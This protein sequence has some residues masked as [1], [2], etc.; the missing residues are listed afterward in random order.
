[1]KKVIRIGSKRKPKV[2]AH[3][4]ALT[5]NLKAKV[6][7]IQALIPI[8]LEAVAEELERDVERL[9]GLKHS[10]KGG[11][12]GHYRWGGQPGS[13][14][15]ADQ[16]VKTRI[17][18][19]RNVLENAEVPLE[20]YRLLQRPRNGDEGVMRKVLY[21]LSCRKYEQCAEAVPE[22]LGLSSSSI[23]RRFIQVSGSRLR[24]LMERDLSGYDFVALFI[25]GKSFAQD[26]MIIALGVTM[27]GEKVI[28]GFIQAAT[29]KEG[30]VKD[31][32]HGL[33]ERGL[34][35]EQGLLCIIDGAKGIRS[36]IQKVFGERALVQRCQWHKRENV[37]DYLPKH[38]HVTW[39]RK[40]QRAYEKPT[41]EEAKAALERLKPEL[42]LIN[43]SA[44]SSLEEGFE[45]TL[46]LHRLGLFP[47][48]GVSFKTTNCIESLMALLS[49][50]TNKV[51]HWR[52]S[53]Q[54][55]RWVATALLEIESGLRR[56]KGYNKLWKLR[57]ALKGNAN[58]LRE[59]A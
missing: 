39:R 28:L 58:P 52:N 3:E 1:M 24:E 30:V 26:E 21:G 38:L 41:Y 55:H 34:H 18:R 23:S 40:L 50:Y 20:S 27:S 51:D 4:M 33:I 46:T 10:R 35:I 32:L 56:V 13:V 8:G 43:V 9:A 45:E 14:Y 31:F 36:A 17:P 49:Q 11:L 12:P 44:L 48:L 53:S 42:K 15:L 22:A 37:V 57:E 47:E 29:E 59:A 6:E 25:D 7:L 16:K 2:T 5:S 54:K 19:V